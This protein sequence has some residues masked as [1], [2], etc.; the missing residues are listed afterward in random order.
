[1]TKTTKAM[2]DQP[3][4]SVIWEGRIRRVRHQELKFRVLPQRLESGVA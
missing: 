2:A 4:A 1:M 3:R